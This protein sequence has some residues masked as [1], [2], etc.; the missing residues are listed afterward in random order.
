MFHFERWLYAAS[1]FSIKQF[2][3]ISES[4]Q[5]PVVYEVNETLGKMERIFLLYGQVQSR[6]FA[7][8]I[9]WQDYK[10]MRAKCMIKLTPRCKP[11]F[12]DSPL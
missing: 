5:K 8:S 4:S 11:L 2:D 1:G 3:V 10:I 7:R 12:L 6:V 9:L